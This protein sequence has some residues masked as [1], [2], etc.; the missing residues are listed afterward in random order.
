MRGRQEELSKRRQTAEEEEAC[1]RPGVRVKRQTGS[2]VVKVKKA[3]CCFTRQR[4][5]VVVEVRSCFS[6]LYIQIQEISLSYGL[7][8][9]MKL[10]KK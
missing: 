4:R 2:R 8:N 9:N 10:F 1:R 7:T 5:R 3:G 6:Q